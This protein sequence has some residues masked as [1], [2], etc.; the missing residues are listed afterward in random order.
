MIDKKLILFCL[1]IKISFTL[2]VFI[3]SN[4]S[5]DEIFK[6]NSFEH[7]TFDTKNYIHCNSFNEDYFIFRG[8]FPNILEILDKEKIPDSNYRKIKGYKYVYFPDGS[9]YNK[10]ADLFPESTI[11]VT[12]YSIKNTKN[13]C[14]LQLS[15]LL[16]YESKKRQV[17]YYSVINKKSLYKHFNGYKVLSIGFAFVFP[18]FILLFCN[19]CSKL[20][21]RSYIIF[22]NLQFYVFTKNIILLSIP[23]LIS[24][25]LIYYIL[26]LSLIHSF[27][28]S[29]IL[30]N[31]M[32]LLDSNSIL[33]FGNIKSLYR[34]YFLLCFIFDGSLNLIFCYIVFYIPIINNIYLFAIKSLVEHIAL[35]L[36]TIKSYE[37]KYFHFYSQYLFEIRHRSLIFLFYVFKIVIYQKVIRFAFL[38]SCVFIGFQIYKII[39][40]YD[41]VDAFYFNYV[42]NGCLELFFVLILIKTF[43]PQNLTIFYFMPVYYD[44]NSKI[45]K[46]Q[47][48]NKENKLN[49]SNLNKNGLKNEYK[50]NNTPLVFINPYSKSNNAFNNAYIGKIAEK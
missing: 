45:Y 22:K 42:I 29:Y 16:Y 44:Y 5:K 3:D 6:D 48:T 2:Y 4:E 24:I 50:K 27:F 18:L 39:F 35:L 8:R 23:L 31:L 38:Y 11:F 37:T 34:K 19:Y 25:I 36:Y 46:T 15:K 30:I 40:L 43:Y 7:I 33:E 26:P 14:H 9:L 1:L 10:Y 20:C 12:S 32:F 49:I 21:N 28:K 47:I 13:N 41:Y 17:V